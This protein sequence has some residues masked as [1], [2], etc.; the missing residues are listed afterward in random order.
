MGASKKGLVFLAAM[1]VGVLAALYQ[2]HAP[3][4]YR[5][6]PAAYSEKERCR[7][8]GRVPGTQISTVPG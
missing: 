2:A 8:G 6:Q 4:V 3:R 7:G 5:N 1:L